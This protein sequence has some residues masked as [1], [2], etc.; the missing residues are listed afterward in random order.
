MEF[1][2]VRVLFDF[3]EAKKK[4]IKIIFRVCITSKCLTKNV[5]FF[6]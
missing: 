2:Y 5:N 3:K 6:L 4:K 1:A